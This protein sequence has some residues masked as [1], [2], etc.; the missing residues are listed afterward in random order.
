MLN[1]DTSY[2]IVSPRDSK[3][4]L[5]FSYRFGDF[6]EQMISNEK[7]GGDAY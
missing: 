4:N 7:D 3:A 6:Q 2:V 5:G 1:S